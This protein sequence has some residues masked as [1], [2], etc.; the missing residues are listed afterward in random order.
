VCRS[1]HYILDF[2]WHMTTSL[3]LKMISI[4]FLATVVH[5]TAGNGWTNV[6]K[7]KSNLSITFPK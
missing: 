1:F 3:T 2:S 4:R 5:P 7:S 6:Y